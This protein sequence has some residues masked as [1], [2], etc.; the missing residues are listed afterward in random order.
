MKKQLLI[1]AL[2]MLASLGAAAQG[3]VTLGVGTNTPAGTLHVHSSELHHNTDLP[4]PGNMGEGTQSLG[5]PDPFNPTTDYYQ[6]VFHITNTATGVSLGDGFTVTQ[7]DGA[8]LFEQHETAPLQF[9][10]G[11]SLLTL[12]ADGKVGI[13]TV[14]NYTFNVQ[15]TTRITGALTLGSNLQAAGN[16]T[17]GGSLRVGNGFFVDAAGNM[18]VQHLRVTTT[19][20]PDYVFGA[21]HSLMTLPEWERYI[22]AHGHLPE[23]P[24]AAEAEQEGVELGEMNRLLLQKV[25]ELTLYIID[26]QKQLNELKSTSQSSNQ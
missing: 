8:L 22:A 1:P 20:W 10:N 13:G 12:S 3:F 5:D 7:T 14:G 16:G 6:T 26:L 9:R 25:E 19:D 21:D 15:G 4:T 23:M 17:I 18:K 24:S 11:S 2:Y